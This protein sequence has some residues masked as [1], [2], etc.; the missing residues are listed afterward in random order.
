VAKKRKFS[1]E[2]YFSVGSPLL[3]REQRLQ[4]NAV[5]KL[6]TAPPAERSKTS[7][8]DGK[9]FFFSKISVHFEFVFGLLSI[10]ATTRAMVIPGKDFVRSYVMTDCI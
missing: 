4:M 5:F 3:N 10:T 9:D 2:L 8:Q 6:M 1:Q 7:V